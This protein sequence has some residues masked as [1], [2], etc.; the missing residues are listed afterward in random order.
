M[1]RVFWKKMVPEALTECIMCKGREEDCSR[2][3]FEC[4]FAQEIWI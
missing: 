1:T 3:F 2:L 4:P